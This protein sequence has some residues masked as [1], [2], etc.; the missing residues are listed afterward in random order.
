L[1]PADSFDKAVARTW[2]NH[3]N[4]SVVPAFFRLLQ[5]QPDEPE[6]HE[7]ALTEFMQALGVLCSHRRG[8]YF[9]GDSFSLVDIAIAPWAVRDFIISIFRGFKRG[10]VKGWQQWAEAL[11]VRPCVRATTSVSY[12]HCQR[13]AYL[14]H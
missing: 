2:I 4:N 11:E 7:R 9:F 3:I 5:A 13:L 12:F 6:K 14:K 1:L 8:R 10:E